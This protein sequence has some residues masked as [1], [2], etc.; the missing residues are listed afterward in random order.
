MD[1]LVNT[2]FSRAY[3]AS[4]SAFSK[5]K[6]KQI[7]IFFKAARFIYQFCSQ[8]SPLPTFGPLG[9]LDIAPDEVINH[10]A[11]FCVEKSIVSW[12]LTEQQNA[13]VCSI[14]SAAFL[15]L[16]FQGFTLARKDIDRKNKPKR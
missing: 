11:Y 2:C 10:A 13:D 7:R 4:Y 15:K 9:L 3:C 14:K 5:N 12:I 1:K 6:L 16:I 8:T